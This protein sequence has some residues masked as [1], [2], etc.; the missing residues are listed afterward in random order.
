MVEIL[1][2]DIFLPNGL[3]IEYIEKGW[4]R[5][6]FNISEASEEHWEDLQKKE[7]ARDEKAIMEADE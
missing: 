2:K 6:W 4:H 1:N 5:S 7:D 3:Y